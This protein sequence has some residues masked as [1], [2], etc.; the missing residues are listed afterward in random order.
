[1][2]AVQGRS[3]SGK[4]TLLSLLG[5]LSRPTS[6]LLWFA[7]EDTAVLTDAQAADRRM[8]GIGFVFQAYNLLPHLTALENVALAV[9]GDRRRSERAAREALG[10]VDL[11]D[12]AGHLPGAMSGGEQQ[13][14]ALARA[15]VNRPRL[16]LADEPTGNLDHENE[17]R[18]LTYLRQSL[19]PDTAAVI[20]SHSDSVVRF[21]DRVVTMADG[22]FVAEPSGPTEG[23]P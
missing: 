2:L 20:V 7:G 19:A 16:I 21:A 18:V 8:S 3:G 4:S 23:A 15:T 17:D 13:R 22:R 1:M 12:R 11:A 6:G 9:R 14:V 10:V 5:L